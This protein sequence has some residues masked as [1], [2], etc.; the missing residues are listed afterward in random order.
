MVDL[1]PPRKIGRDRA[2]QSLL[3]TRCARYDQGRACAPRL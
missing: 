2:R 3:S 1:P